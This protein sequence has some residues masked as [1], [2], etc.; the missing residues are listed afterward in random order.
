MEEENKEKRSYFILTSIIVSVAIIGLW[1]GNYF[2]LKDLPETDRG[3]IGDMFGVI[4]S[5][6]SGL[7][8]AGIILTILL[9][10]QELKYQRE[11][12]RDTRKEFQIQNETLK[13]QRFENT[14]FHLLDQHHQIVNAIDFTYH[15][16][17]K[18]EKPRFLSQAFVTAETPLE[19]LVSVTISGRDVFRYK[20]NKLSEKILSSVT[21]FNEIYL[22]EYDQAKADFGH[23]FR[24]VY[25][26]LKI[27][28]ETNFFYDGATGES[29]IFQIKYRYASILRAQ[30]SDYELGWIFYNCLSENGIEK[31][32]PLVEKYAFFNNLPDNLIPK[33]EHLKLYKDSAYGK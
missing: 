8:L 3:T 28:D 16:K 9:Q 1:L 11:E 12:L 4:N 18:K 23:Y 19:E 20:Y 21:D 30:I 24:N 17:K 14:F 27:V 33:P 26:I 13:I 7:A 32:K 31:F 15:S 10:R 2:A 22:A 5:L 25:R 29:E 6:F